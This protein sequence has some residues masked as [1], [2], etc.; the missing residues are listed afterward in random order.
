MAGSLSALI[1]NESQ[2]HRSVTCCLLLESIRTH[3]NALYKARES[4]TI[5]ITLDY[6]LASNANCLRYLIGISNLNF[7]PDSSLVLSNSVK[8]TSSLYFGPIQ[9]CG[10]ILVF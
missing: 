5:T 1:I 9:K 4:V 10:V 7:Q 2:Q 3:S 6:H 8:D